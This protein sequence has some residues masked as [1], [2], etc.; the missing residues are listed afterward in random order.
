MT[1]QG[2]LE[3]MSEGNAVMRMLLHLRCG[4]EPANVVLN[5]TLRFVDRV[6]HGER[7]FA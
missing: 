3:K 5:F 1:A 6:Q 7:R 4:R 2:N